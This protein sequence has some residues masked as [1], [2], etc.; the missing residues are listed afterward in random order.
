MRVL[1]FSVGCVLICI[2]TTATV[3][4]GDCR[5]V[6]CIKRLYSRLDVLSC[7]PH[8]DTSWPGPKL[9]YSNSIK[10]DLRSDILQE[11]T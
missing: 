4:T 11:F 5:A 3:R 10:P 7:A 8:K 2:S 9:V 6:D 1:K